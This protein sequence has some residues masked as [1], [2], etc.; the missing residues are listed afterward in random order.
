[1]IPTWWNN[2]AGNYVGASV[3][4]TSLYIA[5]ALPVILRLRA[6]S[7]FEHGAWSLGTHHRWINSIAIA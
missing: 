6:V 4:V 5:Y 3:A 1:M 7:R 2:L